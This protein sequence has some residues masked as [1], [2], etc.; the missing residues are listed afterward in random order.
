[1]AVTA[2]KGFDNDSLGPVVVENKESGERMT[3]QAGYARAFD[4]WIPHCASEKDFAANHYV[5]IWAQGAG[6]IFYVWQQDVGGTDRVASSRAGP[7]GGST[8]H[9]ACRA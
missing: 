7:R 3:I 6:R 1:M 5:Q 9:R 2:I 8:M 4:I